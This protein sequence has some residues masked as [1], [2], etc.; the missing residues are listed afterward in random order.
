MSTNQLYI[1][2]GHC[3]DFNNGGSGPNYVP[4]SFDPVKEFGYKDFSDEII[5]NEEIGRFHT[6]D[7]DN[8]EQVKFI[9][10]SLGNYFLD[11]LDISLLVLKF[12][13]DLK[14]KICFDSSNS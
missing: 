5:V 14:M 1:R 6:E 8:Y 7:E 11:Y 3:T 10:I 9:L 4:N 12:C 2:D 13:L